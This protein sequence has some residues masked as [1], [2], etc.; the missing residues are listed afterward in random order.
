MSIDRSD[1]RP[2]TPRVVPEGTPPVVCASSK[3]PLRSKSL[4]LIVAEALAEGA[5][6]CAEIPLDET[7]ELARTLDEIRAQWGLRYPADE[8][9]T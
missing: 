5:T 8:V 4:L 2:L 9:R 7:L 1:A 6:E 3:T